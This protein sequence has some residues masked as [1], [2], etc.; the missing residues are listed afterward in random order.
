LSPVLAKV[1]VVLD[2]TEVITWNV[3]VGEILNDSFIASG[4]TAN[5]E[6]NFYLSGPG[7]YLSSVT[8]TTEA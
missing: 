7:G 5:T 1:I 2:G 3:A 6:Y 4:L 8:V